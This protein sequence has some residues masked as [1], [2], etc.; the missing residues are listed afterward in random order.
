[1]NKCILSKQN[2][3]IKYFINY[4]L[5]WFWPVNVMIELVL[6]SFLFIL[7]T[8]NMSSRTPGLNP[9]SQAME[10]ATSSSKTNWQCQEFQHSS[11]SDVAVKNVWSHISPH[12]SF[13]LV[14]SLTTHGNIFYFFFVFKHQFSRNFAWRLLWA[15]IV[16]PFVMGSFNDE[17]ERCC[18]VSDKILSVEIKI[19]C[20]LCK[21]R[22]PE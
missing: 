6:Y 15:S 4:K 14:W 11:S 16:R 1:M 9:L 19:F 13:L 3:V 10:P 22:W 18:I 12:I 21:I 7:R 17:F 8:P 5:M 20:P 2:Y